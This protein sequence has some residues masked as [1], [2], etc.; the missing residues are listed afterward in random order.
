MRGPILICTLLAS[1]GLSVSATAG[2]DPYKARIDE[3]K[4]LRLAG[5][6]AQSEQL[7]QSVL[8]QSPGNFRATYAQGV[9]QLDRGDARGA[10]ATLNRALVGLRGQAPPDP[11][12]YNTLG[13]G[14]MRLGRLDEAAAAFQKQYQCGCTPPGASKTKLLNNMSLVYRLK[15]DTASALRYQQEATGGAVQTRAA[16]PMAY[17]R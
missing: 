14:L 9:L 8:A 4:Q 16:A 12:I 1:L 13:Y 6:H 5:N 7:V 10:V 11:T 2:Q 3:A 15:G 17:R